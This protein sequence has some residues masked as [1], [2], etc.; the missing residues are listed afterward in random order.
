MDFY[1]TQSSTG[2]HERAMSVPV[3]NAGSLPVVIE[4]EVAVEAID[5]KEYQL[6]KLVAGQAGSVERIGG[7]AAQGLDVDVTRLPAYVHT[8][9]QAILDRIDVVVHNETPT[10]VV[11]GENTVFTTAYAY[12]ATT[13][14]VFLNGIRLKESGDYFE[15]GGT[16]LT[17]VDPP[18][19]GDLLILD[20]VKL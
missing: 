17:F 19:D 4:N 13:P 15:T 16:E 2:L 20:Y 6:L 11:D 3:S 10:G 14:R 12:K 18:Q 7:D 9:L 8:L 1:G 5:H